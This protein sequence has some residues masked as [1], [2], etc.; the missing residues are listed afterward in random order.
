M[1]ILNSK[2][3]LTTNRIHEINSS[4]FIYTAIGTIQLRG[5]VW[6]GSSPPHKKKKIA[7]HP[8]KCMQSLYYFNEKL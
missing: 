8:Q 5:Q 4:T 1:L 7:K 2:K 3:Y 6:L